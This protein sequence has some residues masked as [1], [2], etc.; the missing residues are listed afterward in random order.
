MNQSTFEKLIN[1]YNNLQYK[2]VNTAIKYSGVFNKV[3][4]YIL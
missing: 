1:D 2:K 3:Y 4:K